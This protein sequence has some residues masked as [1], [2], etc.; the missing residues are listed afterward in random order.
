VRYFKLWVGIAMIA[1]LALGITL[2]NYVIAG[3]SSL[4]PGSESNPL[5]SES[6]ITQVVEE[7]TASLEYKIFEMDKQIA[8]LTDTVAA[9]EAQLGKIAA[10]GQRTPSQSTSTSSQSSS[11]TGSTAGSSSSSTSSGQTGTGTGSGS[12]S[13]SGAVQQT[14]MEVVPE[15]GVNVRTGPGISYSIVASLSKGTKVTVISQSGEW[16]EIKLDGNK[17][18]WVSGQYLK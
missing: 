18:G 1:A 2:G 3:G 8:A 7:K 17:S 16:Y 4:I 14:T 13:Q 5:V 10:S 6:Y 15:S 11:G 9:L 12:S